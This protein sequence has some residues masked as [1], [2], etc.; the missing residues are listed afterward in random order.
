MTISTPKTDSPV[1][2]PRWLLT[3]N[4]EL[5]AIG[6]WNSLPARAGRLPDGRTYNTCT[7]ARAVRRRRT[8]GTGRAPVSGNIPN[9]PARASGRRS[10]GAVT[11]A[12]VHSEEPCPGQG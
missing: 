1:T 8:S 10:S 9:V 3:H 12:T 4:R 11:A 6:V 7:S 5:R 2:R